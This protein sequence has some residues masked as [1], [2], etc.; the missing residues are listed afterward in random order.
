MNSTPLK[1]KYEKYK[2]RN[3]A[4]FHNP[5]STSPKSNPKDTPL[6]STEPIDAVIDNLTE[7]EEAIIQNANKVLPTSSL[8]QREL[9]TR[10]LHTSYLMHFDGDSEQYPN[11][12]QN[13]KHGVHNKTIFSAFVRMDRLLSVLDGEVK[14]A[15]SAIR[16]DGPFYAGALKISKQEFGKPLMVSYLKLKDIFGLPP[17]QHDNQISLRNYKQKPQTTITW[18]KTMGHDGV[19]KSVENITKAVRRL[20]NYPRYS[21][22]HD[23]KIINY[24][25]REMSI[26]IF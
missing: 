14:R 11:F 13:F 16:Q 15:V 22:C 7:G 1:S 21:F 19:L 26:E 20:P 24:N 5:V 18:L 8:L 10:D 12:I 3:S 23:F 9:K 6:S 4:P 17:I 2:Q 25:E